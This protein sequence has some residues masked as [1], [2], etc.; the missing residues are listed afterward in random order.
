M[1]LL[2][3]TRKA[4]QLGASAGSA[5]LHAST[6]PSPSPRPGPSSR[7]GRGSSSA[8][9]GRGGRS[10]PR[11]DPTPTQW[12]PNA[13]TSPPPWAYWMPPSPWVMPP[14]PH[15]SAPWTAPSPRPTPGAGILGARPNQAHLSGPAP[16]L[17]DV[18]TAMHTMTLTPPDDNWYMDTGATSHMTS[19]SGSP[20]GHSSHEV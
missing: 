1:L 5:L 18:N 11:P 10:S 16:S 6:T 7:G 17:T 2:D 15:P 9:R 3:E 4:H 8:R 14:C 13:W 20:H 19:S 12:A